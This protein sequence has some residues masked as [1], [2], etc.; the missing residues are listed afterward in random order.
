[1]VDSAD[2]SD[3]RKG[4]EIVSTGTREAIREELVALAHSHLEKMDTY[5]KI[6]VDDAK[7]LD[8]RYIDYDILGNG[9]I[10]RVVCTKYKDDRVSIYQLK[11]FIDDYPNKTEELYKGQVKL[12]CL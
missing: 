9:E 1:M 7:G 6:K 3:F 4:A 2:V 12:E 8:A 11:R 5:E 10:K